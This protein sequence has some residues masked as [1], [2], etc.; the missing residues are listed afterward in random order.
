MKNIEKID[1]LEETVRRNKLRDK[2]ENIDILI[3]FLSTK[4]IEAVYCP[5]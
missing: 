5:R 3:S 2:G 1:I 4:G